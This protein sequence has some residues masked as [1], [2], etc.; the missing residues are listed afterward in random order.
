MDKAIQLLGY[1]P[2]LLITFCFYLI[3]NGILLLPMW[4]YGFYYLFVWQNTGFKGTLY[5][6]TAWL[7]IGIPK[8]LIDII[9]SMV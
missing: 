6:G 5:N 1:M 4:L 8:L 2:M 3:I 9:K 7:F